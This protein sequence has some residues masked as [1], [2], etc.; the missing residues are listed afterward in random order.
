MCNFG[1]S[2]VF[3]Q[4][5][6]KMIFWAS[7]ESHTVGMIYSDLKCHFG[8]FLISVEKGL[9]AFLFA[10]THLAVTHTRRIEEKYKINIVYYEST[11]PVVYSPF[12][13]ESI[14]IF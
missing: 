6:F 5:V 7:V 3:V 1:S 12:V 14:L 4:K 8:S 13:N 10:H 11:T 9:N 2:P